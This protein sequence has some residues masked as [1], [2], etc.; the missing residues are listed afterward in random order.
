[1]SDQMS[2]SPMA[3]QTSI[4]PDSDRNASRA[5]ASTRNAAGSCPS[6]CVGSKAT[7]RP[8]PSMK[9]ILLPPHRSPIRSASHTDGIRTETGPLVE[10]SKPDDSW[11]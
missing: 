7:T 3:S 9:S 2:F 6:E 10:Q 4:R 8:L 1:M 5:F 11:E